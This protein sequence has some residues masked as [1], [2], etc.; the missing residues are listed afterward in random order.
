MSI[1]TLLGAGALA[2]AL[3][4][5]GPASAQP[6]PPPD[7]VEDELA[8]ADETAAEGE[9]EAPRDRRSRRGRRAAPARP[10]LEISPYVEV[11]A[12]MSAELSGEDNDVLSYSSVAAGVDG[13]METRRVT[14]QASYR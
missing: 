4:A 6:G 14:A 1:R 12:G 13:R 5:A 9:A 8:G 3:F 2:A 7:A 11:N 10:R